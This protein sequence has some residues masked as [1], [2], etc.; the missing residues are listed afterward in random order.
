MSNFYK[1]RIEYINNWP[2]STPFEAELEYKTICDNFLEKNGRPPFKPMKMWETCKVKS[3]DIDSNAQEPL[4]DQK[5][6]EVYNRVISHIIEA[7]GLI[8]YKPNLAVFSLFTGFDNF[9]KIV[10]QKKS[11][12][13]AK[14]IANKKGKKVKVN[15]SI[16]LRIKFFYNEMS[17]I[18]SSDNQAIINDILQELFNCIPLDIC[19][20]LY[21]N[22]IKSNDKAYTRVIQNEE[23]GIIIDNKNLITNI[24]DKY[25]LKKYPDFDKKDEI[26]RIK[27][28]DDYRRKAG[29]LYQ[30]NF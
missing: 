12:A 5:I 16:T 26:E 30:K 20:Y 22:L 14:R 2:D 3:D 19:K 27:I 21:N 8:P 7:L 9:S 10:Y 1:K 25:D 24:N 17:N 28:A 6:N 18:S 13:V 15:N 29:R 23:Q 11:Y 4:N